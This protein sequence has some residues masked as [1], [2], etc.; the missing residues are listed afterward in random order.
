MS[1]C[2]FNVRK[3]MKQTVKL[4]IFR[5]DLGI[6]N[7]EL[8]R[9]RAEKYKETDHITGLKSRM[10]IFFIFDINVYIPGYS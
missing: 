3:K 2:N 4:K 1:V 5:C 9:R 7:E 6:I 10:N 8:A